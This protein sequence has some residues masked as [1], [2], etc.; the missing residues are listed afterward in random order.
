MDH[1]GDMAF[2]PAMQTWVEKGIHALEMHA[3]GVEGLQQNNPMPPHHYK[4][5]GPEPA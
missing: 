4:D 3:N 2:T 1:E 5:R